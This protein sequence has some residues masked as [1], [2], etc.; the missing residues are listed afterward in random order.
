MKEAIRLLVCGSR[1]W[2][3]KNIIAAYIEQISKRDTGV[4]CVIEGGAS[5][6]DIIG[7][8]VAQELK[9]PVITFLANWQKYDKKAGML[10]NQQMIDEGK[11][12]FVLAFHNNI[13]ASKG[14]KDMIQRA[15]K[16]N[17]PGCLIGEFGIIESWNRE[18]T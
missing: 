9:I 17:I 8:V 2:K 13:D 7:R 5:G 1:D 14:T 11:P 3:N 18:T 6:A 16:N 4:K 12:D 10:R 15:K